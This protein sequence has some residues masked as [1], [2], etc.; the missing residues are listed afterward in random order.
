MQTAIDFIKDNPEVFAA[1]VAALGILGGIAGNWISAA[2]QAAGGRAQ[3]N[4][5]VDAARI[6]AEAQRAAALREDRKIEIA[7]FVRC[8]RRLAVDLHE[9]YEKDWY[10]TSVNDTW[11]EL[12]QVFGQLELVASKGVRE[13][14]EEVLSVAH[15]GK[16]LAVTRALGRQ[17]R[18]S[19]AAAANA[20]QDGEEAAAAARASLLRLEELRA[21]VDNGGR[22]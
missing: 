1:L 7:A 10:E 12:G 21:A 5:A 20:S 14:A 9:M 3:A 8:A 2:I 6:S 22:T 4:A 13:L 16:E 15:G 19:L 18:E 11:Y 17:T